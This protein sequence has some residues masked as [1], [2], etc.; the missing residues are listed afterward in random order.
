MTGYKWEKKRWQKKSV[1]ISSAV[2]IGIVAMG[3][4]IWLTGILE[5]K[6]APVSAGF[7]G[8]ARENLQ[9]LSVHEQDAE[10]L[11][12]KMI[13]LLALP[14]GRLISW[15]QLAGRGGQ[16]PAEKSSESKPEDQLR[17]GQYLLEQERKKDF[18]SW[19]HDFKGNYLQQNGET[20][21]LNEQQT[22][23]TVRDNLMLLRVLVQSCALWPEQDRYNQLSALAEEL[24]AE[25][26]GR[27]PASYVIAVPTPGPVLDPAATPTPKPTAEPEPQPDKL[28]RKSV[29]RVSSI[30]LYSLQL[31]SHLDPRWQ[32]LYDDYLPIVQGAYLSDNLPL[33]ALGYDQKSGSYIPY[34]GENPVVDIDES[35]LT[36]LHLSEVKAA[37]ETSVRWLIDQIY[38][39]RAVYTQYH[40]TLA[41]AAGDIESLPAYAMI[42]R[43]ARLHQDEALYE[44]T[45][46]R[47][48]W[49]QATSQSSEAL[50]ALFRETESGNY[51]VWAVDNTWALLAMR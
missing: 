19:W 41:A 10:R 48:L 49:H 11:E 22:D 51:Q 25:F 16:P 35:L 38:N 46:Q 21:I 1:L 30:D 32:Q 17:Y 7:P 8:S 14:D 12:K 5:R 29:L 9:T 42:C 20:G 45:I 43:I 31:L 39:H 4:I 24:Y 27:L 13:S 40:L 28:V 15:H 47:L 34:A 44:Q 23:C 2:F 6:P 3:L 50:Y 33:F 36:L 18:L 26:N 37:P